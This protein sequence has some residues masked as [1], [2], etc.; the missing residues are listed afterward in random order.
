[1]TAREPHIGASVRLTDTGELGVIVDGKHP[2]WGVKLP[3]GRVRFCFPPEFEVLDDSG[4]LLAE[5]V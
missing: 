3:S 1:V 5:E 4:D 2:C